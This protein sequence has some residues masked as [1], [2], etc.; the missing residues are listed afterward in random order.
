[1]TYSV[2]MTHGRLYPAVAKVDVQ[3][4]ANQAT[5]TVPNIDALIESTSSARACAVVSAGFEGEGLRRS[6]RLTRDIGAN[7]FTPWQ[8][9][10]RE[11]SSS[12]SPQG[13]PS[14][15]AGP[16]SDVLPPSTP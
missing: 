8:V 5:V 9:P 14:I 15:V 6:S 11:R 13:R 2:A 7:G 4:E 3:A 1:M 10:H 12:A 16:A